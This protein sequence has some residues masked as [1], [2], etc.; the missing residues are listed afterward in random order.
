MADEQFGYYPYAGVNPSANMIYSVGIDSMSNGYKTAY[1]IPTSDYVPLTVCYCNIGGICYAI[2]EYG[3][4]SMRLCAATETSTN[5]STGNVSSQ[6]TIPGTTTSIYYKSLS[7]TSETKFIPTD[8]FDLTS[9]TD[10]QSAATAFLAL[11]PDDYVNI[12]YIG[13]GCSIGGFSYVATGTGV[14]VP[15]TLPVGASLTAD[16]I[17]VTKNGASLDF[18]YNPQTQQIAFTAI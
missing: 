13:N 4:Q 2:S 5:P 11:F 7:A 17:S 3:T 14:L 8:A 9:F 6:Y 1:F 18:T 15:V 10:L 16:N 12:T